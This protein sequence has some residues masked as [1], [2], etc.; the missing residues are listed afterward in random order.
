[1]ISRLAL[2]ALIVMWTSGGLQ[3]QTLTLKVPLGHSA[4]I[5]CAAFSPDGRYLVSGSQ[6]KTLRLW[7]V[8]SGKELITFSGHTDVINAVA[9]SPDGKT[10]ASGA[11]HYWNY[12]EV[13]LWDATNGVEWRTLKLPRPATAV[14]FSTDGYRLSTGMHQGKITMWNLESG[15]VVKSLRTKGDSKDWNVTIDS[16]QF[17]D[18]DHLVSRTN[19]GLREV[20]DVRTGKRLLAE[21]PGDYHRELGELWTTDLVSPDGNF[22]IERV[23][24]YLHQEGQPYYGLTLW[25]TGSSQQKGR[26]LTGHSWPVTSVAY[27]PLGDFIVS[28]AWRTNVWNLTTGSARGYDRSW[29]DSWDYECTGVVAVSQNGKNIITPW[30]EAVHMW[31]ARTG[32]VVKTL[33]TD[34]ESVTTVAYSPLGYYVGCGTEEGHIW[35]WEAYTGKHV[36]TFG[37]VGNIRTISFSPDE[38]YVA[39]GSDDGE[40][41]LWQIIGTDGDKLIREHDDVVSSVLFSA[42]GYSII[43]GSYDGTV[44]G[45]GW[46]GGYEQVNSVAI[47]PDSTYKAI[48]SSDGSVDIIEI[49]S[50]KVVNEAVDY[51]DKVNS[52]AFSPDS[53]FVVAGSEDGRI[54][55]METKTGNEIAQLIALDTSEWIVLAPSG[56]FDAS[57]GAMKLMHFTYGLE[58]IALD[59]L[60]ERYYEPGL[61]S[62]L[63]G[64]NPE[65]PREVD[66][67]GRVELYPMVSAAMDVESRL[68]IQLTDRGGGIGETAILLNGTEIISD[69]RTWGTSDADGNMSITIDLQP[70]RNYVV[71]GNNMI[72]VKAF[73]SAHYLESP[74]ARTHFNASDI[75]ARDPNL[76]LVACGVADYFGDQIDL[77]FPARD[78]RAMKVALEQGARNLFN[79]FGSELT[80]AFLLTTDQ[81]DPSL[82]PTKENLMDVFERIAD[83]ARSSDILVVYLSGHGINWGGQ[84][85]DFYYLTKEAYTANTE[86]YNDPEIRENHAIA[87]AALVDLINGIPAQK[88]VLMIDACGSGKAIENLMEKRSVS[89]T[90]VRALDRMRDRTGTHVISGCAADAVSYEASRFGQGILTYAL[91]EGM[92]GAS[93]RD[94]EFVDVDLLFHSAQDRVPQLAK[95][96]GGI[97]EP[98]VFSPTTSG[99]FDIGRLSESDREQIELS[100]AKPIFLMSTFLDI[101]KKRDILSIG[102]SLDRSLIEL[103]ARGRNAPLV[104]VNARSFP[105]GCQTSGIYATAEGSIRCDITLTCGERE[106]Q[107]QL[108]APNSEELVRKMTQWVS[109]LRLE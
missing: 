86:A 30:Q 56:L 77:T 7:D 97:Q 107:T 95:D 40:V 8:E 17:I 64:L 47:S 72:E 34:S 41:W 27:S 88:R 51:T 25:E 66:K 68:S 94:G 45:E 33:E 31:D 106:V 42:D 102:T 74:A 78:A 52:V 14:A 13:K 28:D 98:L 22:V 91:L 49:H 50:G 18:R 63:M 19:E 24:G 6:D 103:S 10:I 26:I 37:P 87:S 89:S 54:R 60:K 96:I 53:R 104:F 85:G 84:D 57:P 48:G 44:V 3:S 16:L 29:V 83:S 5:T 82:Q 79:V 2:P 20:W 99:S 71:V 23:G 93:L 55:I 59:Q 15:K 46:S 73:N 12:G 58:V 65:K 43:S 4:E 109:S 61:L 92:K 67:M 100:P 11:G 21:N 1:M 80:H 69:A 38:Q 36:K 90:T 108:T 62:K 76:W 32:G 105:D 9:F 35:V 70:F 101:D 81:S 39:S 75:A